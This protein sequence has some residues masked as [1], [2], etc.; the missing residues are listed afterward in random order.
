MKSATATRLL[1]MLRRMFLCLSVLVLSSGLVATS[2]QTAR[3]QIGLI[4][5]AEIEGLLRYY[6]VPLFR[7]AGL[8]PSSGDHWLCRRRSVSA[9]LIWRSV[10]LPC[11]KVRLLQSLL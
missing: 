4:R 2:P 3:A 9:K 5:D 6:A 11:M 10:P 8:N 1:L 7:V